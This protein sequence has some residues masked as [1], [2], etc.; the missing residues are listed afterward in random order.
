[1][2]EKKAFGLPSQKNRV[3]ISSLVWVFLVFS[4][5]SFRLREASDLW[6]S[7]G[8]D[9][10]VKFQVVSWLFLGVL[11]LLLLITK[12]ADLGLLRRGPLLFYC[13]FVLM[14][15]ISALYSLSPI[16]TLF[17]SLQL[18]IAVVLVIS[19]RQRLYDLYFYITVF[20]ILNWVAFLAG[21]L[22]VG[23]PTT[24]WRLGS[25]FG[26]PTILG[27][28]SAVGAVGVFSHAQEKTISK[29]WWPVLIVLALTTFLSGSRSAMAGLILGS[30]IVLALRRRVLIILAISSLVT[31]SLFFDEVRS[32]L[33]H[34]Y[35]RGQSAIQVRS[36]SGR[37]IIY[38]SAVKRM[39]SSLIGG[40]GFMSARKKLLVDTETQVETH[41]HNI[42]LDAYLNLGLIGCFFVTAVIWSTVRL[43]VKIL[44]PQRSQ[45]QTFR[46]DRVGL[47]SM[48]VPLFAHCISDSGFVA[49]VSPYM[50]VFIG[51]MGL[52]QKCYNCL[53]SGTVYDR[54]PG[55]IIAIIVSRNRHL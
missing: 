19:T 15:I 44:S 38:Q 25:V 26:S 8:F 29:L 12:K 43:V 33:W 39:D 5:A 22:H 30:L 23:D 52:T 7:G 50:M 9:Q 4:F 27:T 34:Y 2:I 36:M 14:A 11:A 18:A 41:A 40:E 1:M 20:V 21:F 6:T 3:I 45:P 49:P 13:G 51:I 31:F 54:F 37:D 24:E 48:L 53:W 28:V 46:T 16:L 55:Q 17:R 32:G 35:N 47:L 10:Q 42:Y